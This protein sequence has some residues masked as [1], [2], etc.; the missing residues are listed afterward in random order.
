MIEKIVNALLSRQILL[1]NLKEEDISVYRYGYTLMFER[2]IN[3]IIT[4][5]IVA[6]TGEWLI[7]I[8]F[9]LSFIPIR[10]YAGGWHAEK[11]IV[12]TVLS[13]VTILLSIIITDSIV[14]KNSIYIVVLEAALFFIIY[15]NAP[16][17]NKNKK[18]TE[19]E[20]HTYKKVTL[21][22]LIAEMAVEALLYISG[23][24]R[25]ITAVI[26]AQIVS[27]TSIVVA[28]RLEGKENKKQKVTILP[29]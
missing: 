28:I 11:F 21:I 4:I 12:C 27:A 6:I 29:K 25:I 22:I 16:V 17:Q 15:R 18:L 24:Y 20:C 19:K 7:V 2:I 8:A 14:I 26:F 5:L 3:Y 10:S 9:L 23:N 13:N 1:G